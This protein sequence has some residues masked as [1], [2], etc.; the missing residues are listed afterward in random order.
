MEG[1][2]TLKGGG[3]DGCG[4]FL[5][6]AGIPLPGAPRPWTSPAPRVCEAHRA[7]GR[8]RAGSRMAT[9]APV[10]DLAGLVQCDALVSPAFHRGFTE[11]L[12][13]ARLEA[14]G[15]R[16]G[17]TNPWGTQVEKAEEGSGQKDQRG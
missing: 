17:T 3:G 4:H 8:N 15:R 1:G 6:E 14:S 5:V 10:A 13:R 11:P 12:S 9:V 16:Q 2:G 7:G